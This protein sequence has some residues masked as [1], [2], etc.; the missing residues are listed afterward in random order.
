MTTTVTENTAL[1]EI[2]D[3]RRFRQMALDVTAIFPAFDTTHFLSIALA[4]LEELSLMQRLRRMTQAL[5]TT[6]PAHYRQALDI[7]RAIAPRM[8]TGLA[9]LVLPDYVGQYGQDDFDIS[10][11]ALR[12][13]TSFGSSEFAVREFLRRDLKRTLAV[14]ETWSCDA[15]ADVRRLASEGSRP[16]LPWSFRVDAIVADP[17]LT[18]P[19]LENLRAD[20][21]PYVRKS[22]ANHLN[23][24]TKAHPDQVLDRLAAWP[25]EDPHSAW[26][27]RHALRSLIKAGNARALAVIG[28]GG[29]PRVKLS[30]LAVTPARVALGERVS[31]SFDLASGSNESQRLVIDYRMHYVKKSGTTAGKVF[32]LKELTLGA[33]ERV[34]IERTQHIRDFTTRVHYAGRHEIEILVNGLCLAKG[35]F[36]LSC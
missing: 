5:H 17:A 15:S 13:F 23:D 29:V 8:D 12:Y 26:I 30:S 18:A 25:L 9:T 1:K 2:F 21:S 22:V 20:P 6:L 16:R 7:L 19:I 27:A 31:F 34:S 4:G 3:E 11:D 35:F 33:G 14:M 36:D 28:A 10:L 32:K 24:M